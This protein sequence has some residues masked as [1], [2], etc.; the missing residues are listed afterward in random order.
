[1]VYLVDGSSLLTTAYYGYKNLF[2]E[3]AAMNAI[4]GF[5]EQLPKLT[6]MG[7]VYVFFDDDTSGDRRKGLY[8]DYKKNRSVL[9]RQ[10][11]DDRKSII[12]QKNHLIEILNYLYIPTLMLGEVEADDLI[13]QCLHFIP[14]KKIT[15]VSG[16]QDYVQLI[17]E[18]VSLLYLK[19]IKFKND[20]FGEYKTI[21]PKNW[22]LF[23]DIPYYNFLVKKILCGDSSDNI[24]G[25][26]LYQSKSL[27]KDF[28]QILNEP[29]T[30]EEIVLKVK[31]LPKKQKRQDYI[32]E[33][34][35]K[36]KIFEQIID[37]KTPLL[38]ENENEILKTFLN[39]YI[40]IKKKNTANK[41][42]DKMDSLDFYSYIKRRNLNSIRFMSPYIKNI[43]NILNAK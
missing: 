41:L 43:K 35:N 2:Y 15:I 9:T 6:Q 40:D 4:H 30:F 5:L 24:G 3:K 16:D 33:D 13:A 20:K 38:N 10:K 31:E 34:L 42:A 29:L 27:I 11:A 26:R 22:R 19:K 12:E 1:M 18:N 21:T 17:N 23:F 14:N 37:L 39:S 8:P 36:L 25:A 28:P 7:N 32:L